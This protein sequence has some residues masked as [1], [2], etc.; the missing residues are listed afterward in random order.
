LVLEDELRRGF[1]STD[2]W[3]GKKMAGSGRV[4]ELVGVLGGSF[5]GFRIRFGS[6]G[7]RGRL[8]F[9]RLLLGSLR[10]AERF[11]ESRWMFL[12]SRSWRRLESKES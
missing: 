2:V 7:F 11:L 6:F 10:G 4:H 9:G 8:G 3:R 1:G 5:V 12:E